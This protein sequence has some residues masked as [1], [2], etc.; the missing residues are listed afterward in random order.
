MLSWLLRSGFDFNAL[1]SFVEIITVAGLTAPCANKRDWVFGLVD[2]KQF[3]PQSLC[4]LLRRVSE[5]AE[6]LDQ[7]FN[8]CGDFGSVAGAS[9]KPLPIV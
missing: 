4:F 8:D 5:R 2:E 6:K 3:A 9:K 1:R 7:I